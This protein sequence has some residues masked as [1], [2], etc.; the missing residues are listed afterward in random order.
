MV[1]HFVLCVLAVKK[2]GT[3]NISKISYVNQTTLRIQK[4]QLRANWLR[5]PSQPADKRRALTAASRTFSDFWLKPKIC[6]L[7]QGE[8]S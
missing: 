5:V 1:V 6:I 2:V 7:R 8:C 4:R 3:L